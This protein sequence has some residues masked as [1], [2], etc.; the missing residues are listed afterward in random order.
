METNRLIDFEKLMVIKGDGFGGWDGLGVWDGNV[1]KLGCDDSCIT[2]NTVK[3]I[4]V[5]K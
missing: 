5:K 2:L 4:E 3:F 1:L